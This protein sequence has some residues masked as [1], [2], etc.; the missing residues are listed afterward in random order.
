MTE[1]LKSILEALI[2]A[3]DTPLSAVRMKE[4]LGIERSA[5][6][7]AMDELVRE[8]NERRG[9]ICLQEVAGGFQFRTNPDMGGWIKKLK[10]GKPT[11]LS[12]A[13]LE[14]LAIIAYRQPVVR[15]DIERMRGGV[16]VSSPLKGLLDKK[17]VKMVGRKDVPGKPMLYGTTKKF[18]EIFDLKDLSELPTLRDLKELQEK[19]NEKRTETYDFEEMETAQRDAQPSGETAE[20]ELPGEPAEAEQREPDAESA[21]DEAQ[22]AEPADTPSLATEE[23]PEGP[24][25]QVSADVDSAASEEPA[26]IMD[27]ETF[28]AEPET[29]PEETVPEKTLEESPGQDEVGASDETDAEPS[30]AEERARVSGDA[31]ESEAAP[32]EDALEPEFRGDEAQASNGSG[33]IQDFQN[34]REP[35]KEYG[36]AAGKQAPEPKKEP[37]ND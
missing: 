20:R 7:D 26:G 28:E 34:T 4:V 29:T 3:S 11:S 27:L 19:Y 36:E 13:A 14:T 22:T 6:A 31:T 5:I 35:Q 18:L 10:G 8:Y 21:A 30:T 23:E 32:P 33:E 17:L 2:L 16:D 12:Q 15:A 9:G 24:A 25:A 37:S 1:N